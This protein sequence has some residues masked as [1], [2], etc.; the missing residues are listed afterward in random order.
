MLY[1]PT[2]VKY[3]GWG[4]LLLARPGGKLI[5]FALVAFLFVCM[6]QEMVSG[7]PADVG[8]TNRLDGL[9]TEYALHQWGPGDGLPSSTIQCLLQTHDGYLWIGTR[10]GLF[11]FDGKRFV[12]ASAA[13]C[14]CL[15]EDKEGFLWV[16]AEPGLFCLRGPALERV[17]LPGPPAASVFDQTVFSVCPCPDGGIWFDSGG[18]LYRAT[19]YHVD[20]LAA[21]VGLGNNHGLYY[22][23]HGRL[24]ASTAAGLQVRTP[25]NA[26]SIPRVIASPAGRVCCI[27]EDTDGGIWFG[28]FGA[29]Y[30]FLQ[31]DI[32]G[33]I[34]QPSAEASVPNSASRIDVD[35]YSSELEGQLGWVLSLVQDPLRTIWL[36]TSSGLWVVS[37]H[38]LVR[39][40]GLDGAAFGNVNCLLVDREGNLFLGTESK[41]LFCLERKRFITKTTKDGLIHD[42]VWSVSAAPDGSVW[43]GTSGGV[44]HYTQGV[45]ANYGV[46]QGLLSRHVHIVFADST[47][48]IWAGTEGIAERPDRPGGLYRLEHNKF[49]QIGPELGIVNQDL[50][51]VCENQQ[52]H[53]LVDDGLPHEWF[54]GVFHPYPMAQ[55][56]SDIGGFIFVDH[57]DRVWLCGAVLDC[58]GIR[59]QMHYDL[60]ALVGPGL[61]GVVHEDEHGAFWLG[62]S[63]QGLVRF[64]NGQLRAI[65]TSQGLFSNLILSLQED[66]SGNYWMNC[67][68]GIFRARKD[69]LNAV[70]DGR[71]ASLQCVVY[72]LDDGLLSV[73]GNGG[74]LPNS[75]KTRDGRLWF[76]TTQGIA[77]VDPTSTGL[78]ALPP[79]VIIE[80]LRADGK[81]LYENLLSVGSVAPSLK[82]RPFTSKFSTGRGASGL[83]AT[84]FSHPAASSGEKGEEMTQGSK[85]YISAPSTRRGVENFHVSGAKT[86]K[87]ILPGSKLRL[88]PGRGNSLELRFTATTLVPSER[89]H[90]KYRLIGRDKDWIDLGTQRFVSLEDLPHGHYIF[91]VTACNRHGIWN[92]NGAQFAFQLVPFFYETWTFYGLCA[93]GM[94][95]AAF[96]LQAYRLAV[97]RKILR[98]QHETALA[99]ER[100]RIAR[101]MH[102]DLGAGL[103]RIALLTEVA[104]KQ[105]PDQHPAG[106]SMEHVSGIARQVVDG[107]SELI[108]VANPHFDTLANLVAYLREYAARFCAGASI[109][110]RLEFPLQTPH[111]VLPADFR[112]QILL[113]LKEALN[114][115]QKH[116]GATRVELL[117][118]LAGGHLELTVR[119][120]G[121]GFKL[122][123]RSGSGHGLINMRQR[124]AALNGTC[125]IECAPGR[126]TAL[127][128]VLPLP[129]PS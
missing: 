34:H 48:A 123:E 5:G 108:W 13:N 28:G 14:L 45:F 22:S 52:R 60:Q 102:D 99:N 35:H 95:L 75:C 76:P 118:A 92:E 88:P 29:V 15:A 86:D 65:T 26:H 46:N 38:R 49:T 67:H 94:A 77:I 40:P 72:G 3:V 57:A 6:S 116:S 39:P 66:A 128:F 84:A 89:V 110:C 64:K 8:H 20:K 107:I 42:D 55:A 27:G 44:S 96:G 33:Q 25:T 10:S 50:F 73:E 43:I 59:P 125:E 83:L 80:S 2:Q 97:Q 69:D 16:G 117:L 62:S 85:P 90:F 32:A 47:G 56:S 113:M 87:G 111:F 82:F 114:N 104:R 70:A 71:R 109:E 68:T 58:V 9:S 18:D 93:I 129:Q 127:R 79:P 126:G 23:R 98:L 53:V 122:Q 63:R 115:V 36:G 112:R 119:D 30:R 54:G 4:I 81:V 100:E 121:C 11:R 78:D 91:N 37:G 24:Y 120:N 74:T 103:T 1:P 12:M 41:G 124:A 21:K 101:D 19:G 17:K 106:A 31:A 7:S 61:Y 105:L 51:S